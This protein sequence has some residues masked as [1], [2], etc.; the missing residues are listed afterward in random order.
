V[1]KG[2]AEKGGLFA[3]AWLIGV[4]MKEIERDE[5]HNL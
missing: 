4:R 1:Y 3:L 2:D 5:E